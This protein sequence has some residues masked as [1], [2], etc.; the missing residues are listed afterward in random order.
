MLTDNI[1]DIIAMSSSVGFKF[2]KNSPELYEYKFHNNT[3]DVRPLL[4]IA[5]NT[6]TDYIIGNKSDTER[7][8]AREE[9]IKNYSEMILNT[10]N[11]LQIEYDRCKSRNKYDLFNTMVYNHDTFKDYIIDALDYGKGS[12]Y[13]L[14]NEIVLTLASI[15]FT[16]DDGVDKIISSVYGTSDPLD[17]LKYRTDLSIAI[18]TSI[19]INWALEIL[20]GYKGSM[21]L[22][23]EL[24][25]VIPKHKFISNEQI[26]KYSKGKNSKFIKYLEGKCTLEELIKSRNKKYKTR[27][28][29]FQ[30]DQII[31]YRKES[32]KKLNKFLEVVSDK[33]LE[34]IRKRYTYTWTTLMDNLE[35]VYKYTM[36]NDGETKDNIAKTASK[37]DDTRCEV[38][39]LKSEIAELNER[40]KQSLNQDEKK[41]RKIEQLKGEIKQLK[42]RNTELSKNKR[43]NEG[44]ENFKKLVENK[45]SEIESLNSEIRALNREIKELKKKY[46]DTKKEARLLDAYREYFGDLYTDDE[47]VILLEESKSVSFDDI[48]ETLKDYQFVLCSW[49]FNKRLEQDLTKLGLNVSIYN[50]ENS[51]AVN[52]QFDIAIVHATFCS[53]PMMYSIQNRSKQINALLLYF[54]GA[55]V[56]R[57]LRAV[58]NELQK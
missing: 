51:P 1:K 10:N 29:D 56:E 20:L 34:Y 27:V 53:H 46:S 19:V 39:K 31:V 17:G 25:K 41:K 42:D 54:S 24:A 58:Y 49:D 21:K 18:I 13:L 7:M 44:V 55:N 11:K 57:M 22:H 2:P 45:D 38:D 23:P 30:L 15:L 48:V 40:L 26:L 9:S 16:Y 50:S 52:T 33:E 36:C 6:L 8:I 3:V 35:N 32:G 5:Y 37:L 12:E 43:L 47:D 4:H 28:T 14:A